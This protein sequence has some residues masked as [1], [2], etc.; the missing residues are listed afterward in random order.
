MVRPGLSCTPPV[1]MTRTGRPRTPSSCTRRPG[2]RQAP[3]HPL[4]T[5]I[6]RDDLRQHELST[7]STD[8]MTPTN[9]Y[10][11]RS[12][13]EHHTGPGLGTTCP[14]PPH[15]EGR[16]GRIHLPRTGS[17]NSSLPGSLLS[18]TSLLAACPARSTRFHSTEEPAVKF[19]VER[20]VFADAVAWA[21][22]SLPVRP[23]APVLAGLLIEASN[24]G[25]VLSTFDYETSARADLTAQ[26]SDDG[27]ALVSGRLL[28][29]IC[30]SLPNK[31]VDVRARGPQGPAHLRLRPL[32]PPDHAGRGLPQAAR[33]A[34]RHR[35]RLQQRLRPRGRP[36][37]HRRRSRRHAP[38]AHRRTH[39][40]RRRR[41]CR[42]SPPTG[43]GS[44]TASSPGT[45]RPRTPPSPPWSPPR[46]SATPPS[47]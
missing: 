38:G 40:D 18:A 13:V 22:R 29:D 6:E 21:A 14:A 44:R 24:E 11:D 41:P 28:A 3:A 8:A 19:R 39:R 9:L 7:V 33:D 34:G 23:S 46:C 43:S 4:C 12:S 30:R 1:G 35:H 47:R 36:G 25:L 37:R 20:D 26:V 45:P 15:D 31:P 27:S 5:E 2:G 42:C 32:Q 17:C 16:H 10:M